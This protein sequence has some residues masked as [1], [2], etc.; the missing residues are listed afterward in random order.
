V[1]RHS[2]GLRRGAAARAAAVRVGGGAAAAAAASLTR[3]L[4]DV[5]ADPYDTE[6]ILAA[7]PSVG[8]ELEKLLPAGFC[9]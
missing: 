3:L 1:R 5:A 2:D 8:A 9:A 4:Y 7:H 6:N